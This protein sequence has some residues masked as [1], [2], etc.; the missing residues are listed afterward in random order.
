VLVRDK[1]TPVVHL[2][3]EFQLGL[4][5][6]RK[7]PGKLLHQVFQAR[8]LRLDKQLSASGAPSWLSGLLI[9]TDVGGALGLFDTRPARAPVYVVGS[10]ELTAC[11]ASAL[12]HH[13]CKATVIVG[14]D[15]ALRGLAL[16]FRATNG[17]RA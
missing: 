10:P 9:G 15:A 13:G 3:D 14:A 17:S 12:E 5:E 2:A 4:A 1:A 16:V 7:H 8:S 11:Y 6:A